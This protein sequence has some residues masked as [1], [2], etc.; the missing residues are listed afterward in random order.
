MSP[1]ALDRSEN[2]GL[3]LAAFSLLFILLLGC[4]TTS[5]TVKSSTTSTNQS[6]LSAAEEPE[7]KMGSDGQNVCGYDCQ[8][9]S[10]GRVYCADT[11]DGK[12]SFN[13]DGTYTCTQLAHTRRGVNAA[14]AEEPEC[15]LQSNGREVCGYNCRTGSSGDVYCSSTPNGRCKLNSDGSFSCP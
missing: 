12:C 11:P 5:G 3:A 14:P 10:N 4:S 9:G 6:G 8:M 7:C 2:V 15:K 13:A 1:T